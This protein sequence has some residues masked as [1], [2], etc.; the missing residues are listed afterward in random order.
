[1]QRIPFEEV[2]ARFQ[3]AIHEKTAIL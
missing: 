3:L 2:R 1:M